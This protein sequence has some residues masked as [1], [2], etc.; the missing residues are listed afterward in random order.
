M[1]DEPSFSSLA[2]I[3]IR[4]FLGSL[5][6]GDYRHAQR[7]LRVFAE[8]HSKEFPFW[9]GYMQDKFDREYRPGPMPSE[10]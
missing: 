9:V 7:L 2:G 1:N 4:I 6:V 5:K 10:N 3:R 8:E